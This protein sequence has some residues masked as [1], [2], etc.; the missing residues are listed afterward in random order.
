MKNIPYAPLA[1]IEI[2]K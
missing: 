1:L 2:K